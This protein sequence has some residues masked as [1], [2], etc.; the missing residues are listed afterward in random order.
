[1]STRQY[2]WDSLEQLRADVH[3]MGDRVEHSLSEAMIALQERDLARAERIDQEDQ[4]V[5][6]LE[7]VIR[8]R[9]VDLLGTQQPLARDLRLV[10]GTLEIIRDLERAGDHA[11]KIARSVKPMSGSS[12]FATQEAITCLNRMAVL[13]GKMLK[14]SV[15]SFTT[16]ALSLLEEIS[17][18][19]AQVDTLN[20]MLF[21]NV[22]A[23]MAAEP[24]NIPS[25]TRVLFMAR[26]LERIADHATNIAE[27]A[28]YVA[29][30][31]GNELG[32]AE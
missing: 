5:D 13:A 32:T 6:A 1:M 27:R 21:E 2:Y 12:S 14:L 20:R 9:C 11:A 8:D 29:G 18:A 16:G 10:V 19:E 17:A 3:R 31:G 7:R 15:N 25:A 23:Q 4:E 28:A 22:L 24:A 26:F 30:S